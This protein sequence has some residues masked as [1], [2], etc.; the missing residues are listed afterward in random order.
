L[1]TITKPALGHSQPCHRREQILDRDRHAGERS[2][3][4]RLDSG[5]GRKGVLAVDHRPVV[6]MLGRRD[7]IER[8]LHELARRHLSRAN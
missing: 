1:P 6:Q 8:P 4:A 3:V 2:L 5:R 7:A